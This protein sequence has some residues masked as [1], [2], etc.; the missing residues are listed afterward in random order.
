MILKGKEASYR[1]ASHGAV[2]PIKVGEAAQIGRRAARIGQ[3]IVGSATQVF[4]HMGEGFPVSD[5]RFLQ[6]LRE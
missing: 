3:R 2:A 5:N 6:E 1:A 4:Q